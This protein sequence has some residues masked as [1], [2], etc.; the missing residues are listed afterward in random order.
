MGAVFFLGFMIIV[1][2]VG[3]TI[4]TTGLVGCIIIKVYKHKKSKSVKKVFKILS[5]VGLVLGFIITLI[6][7]SFGCF[8]GYVNYSEAQYK[9]TIEYAADEL[10]Y[11]RVLALLEKGTD[12]DE[13]R[14]SYTPLMH[15]CTVSDTSSEGYEVA[16]LLI[17]YG[18]NVNTQFDGY[19]DGSDKGYSALFYAVTFKEKTNLVQLLIDNK[20]DI[21]HRATDG[22]TPLT[23]A[24]EMGEIGIGGNDEIIQILIDNGA[25]E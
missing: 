8:I 3:L 11:D 25:S 1:L 16:K 13:C 19:D 21:N 4:F 15:V 6:P 22:K 14:S 10:N 7:I 12:P 23:I 18:A 20:A 9:K 2:I 17:Q 24:K 5:V